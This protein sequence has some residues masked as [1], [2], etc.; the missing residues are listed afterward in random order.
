M[1][2]NTSR[3]SKSKYTKSI[4]KRKTKTNQ[5]VA[6]LTQFFYGYKGVW[7]KDVIKYLT[8]LTGLSSK[9]LNKWN[10]DH[11]EKEMELKKHINPGIMFLVTNTRT[12]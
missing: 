4:K 3:D 9:Q 8:E 12:G 5:Q 2:S 1:T 6:T 7:D 10:W 11:C